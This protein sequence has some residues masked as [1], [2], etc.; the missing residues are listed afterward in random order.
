M[1]ECCEHNSGLRRRLRDHSRF[2]IRPHSLADSTVTMRPGAFVL[3]FESYA[4]LSGHTGM[5]LTSARGKPRHDF[6]SFW[7]SAVSRSAS[8]SVFH[9]QGGFVRNAVIFLGITWEIV[10]CV[11][12]CSATHVS[13]S[14]DTLFWYFWRIFSAPIPV[15]FVVSESVIW[16]RFINKAYSKK[17]KDHIQSGLHSRANGA[18]NLGVFGINPWIHKL[19][20]IPREPK[21]NRRM[22]ENVF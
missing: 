10:H 18:R 13:Y 6:K 20:K 1:C 8:S 19:T 3:A 22:L 4:A 2:K 11:N 14:S 9:R 17:V 16:E 5:P 15:T 21:H 7:K 12:N